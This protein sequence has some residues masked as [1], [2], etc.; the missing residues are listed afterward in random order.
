MRKSSGQI[1]MF[2]YGRETDWVPPSEF[3]DLTPFDTVQL[4][5]ET[6]GKNK[7]VDT[8]VA[9]CLTTPDGKSYFLP[10]KM[11]GGG[12]MP[13]DAADRWHKDILKKKIVNLNTGFDVEIGRNVGWNFE[14]QGC[15]CHDIAHAAALL[16]E[17]RIKGFNLKE[18]GQEYVKE[19]R[20]LGD[21]AEMS[22]AAGNQEHIWRCHSSAIGPQGEQWASLTW[23]IHLEQQKQIKEQNLEE[24]QQL[25][26]DIIWANAH[27][28]RS[29]ARLDMPLLDKWR[30]D[31]AID[32]GDSLLD[33]YTRTGIYVQ[34]NAKVGP[35]S[36]RALFDHLGLEIETNDVTGKE[37]F[38]AEY[39]ERK[40]DETINA[41]VMC[42]RLLS[43]QSKYLD[44]YKAVAYDDILRFSL[45]QLRSVKDEGA[46]E[47]DKGTIT[48]RYSCTREN[49]QQVMKVA[50]QYEVFGE[51]FKYIIRQ[52]FI[53]DDGFDMF[54]ADASQIEF[55]FFAHFAA[56][57]LT[58]KARVAAS[59]LVRQYCEDP[60][61]DFHMLVTIM[62]CPGVTDK[63]KLKALRSTVYKHLNFGILYGMGSLKLSRKQS[64]FC[65]CGEPQ[66]FWKESSHTQ[67][68]PALRSIANK[69]EYDLKFPAAK[70]LLD[71]CKAIV[72][73]DGFIADLIGRRGRFEDD[74]DKSYKA[75]N[76]LLQ[77]SAASAFKRKV[78]SLYRNM[79]TI[80]IHKLRFPVHDEQ[81]GDID[82]DPAARSRLQE[83]L[84]EQDYRLR[85]PLMWE[86]SF[87]ANWRECA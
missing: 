37:T 63:Q 85:V 60:K 32:I 36:M 56:E 34:P 83:C 78:L 35:R 33:I 67:G 17:N 31:I 76:K 2:E 11:D 58:G 28:E 10:Y 69:R 68:C 52:L 3:P 62:M 12:N 5:F 21:L 47:G 22:N 19:D 59:E 39:L 13:Y 73:R 74:M 54:A 9:T 25:E 51:L 80:G 84:A 50:K 15:E 16:N 75:L 70:A 44:K 64:L 4:N 14:D 57:M 26:D 41:A 77:G 82:K 46:D 30:S 18:L 66:E 61:I 48:G 8:P 81:V 23:K 79:K 24:V 49:I 45:Y 40:K 38:A 43:I 27:M 20:D 1:S 29:G 7:F 6:T 65:T 87:G 55:R 86:T 71:V 72:E 42:R 53:P